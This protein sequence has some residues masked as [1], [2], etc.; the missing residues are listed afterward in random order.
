ME[1]E[2]ILEIEFMP[3]WDRWAWKIT[4]QNVDILKRGIF[5]NYDIG[6]LSTYFPDFYK[7]Q[8]F[9]FIKGTFDKQDDKI[10][11]F[12]HQKKKH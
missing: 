2:N 9:L 11:I 10:N 6:V 1:K 8:G 5:E 3:V 4:K 12:V 7:N